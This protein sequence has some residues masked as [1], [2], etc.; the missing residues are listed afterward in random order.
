[1][2]NK[3]S[4]DRTNPDASQ[5]RVPGRDDACDP[6]CEPASGPVREAG[7]TTGAGNLSPG[8]ANRTGGTTSGVDPDNPATPPQRRDVPPSA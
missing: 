6:F 3:Q 1:M 4:Q 8:G 5:D 2:T 7:G